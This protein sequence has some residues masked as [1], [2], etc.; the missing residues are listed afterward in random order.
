MID[1]R[2]FLKRAGAVAVVA[3]VAPQR[4]LDVAASPRL[5]PLSPVPAPPVLKATAF[6]PMTSEAIADS[7]IAALIREHLL[8]A[9]EQ[10]G[11]GRV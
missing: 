5:P 8:W 2:S 7:G 4:L 6:V 3:A 11:G 10:N 9:L 1:R